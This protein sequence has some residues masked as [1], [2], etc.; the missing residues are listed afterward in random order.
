MTAPILIGITGKAGSGKDSLGAVFRELADFSTYALASPIKAALAAMLRVPVT[1]IEDREF[2]NAVYPPLG[3]TPRQMLQ[4]LGTEW[5]RQLVCEDIWLN[6]MRKRWAEVQHEIPPYLCVTDIR[7]D[8]EANAI[9]KE[10]GTLIRIIR[11]DQIEGDSHK[12]E[13]GVDLS[14]VDWTV[15]NDGS[16]SDL[17]THAGRILQCISV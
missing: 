15:Y 14:F 17:K 12:S 13:A 2:K 4:T 1:K 5:G 8:N 10:G 3:K 9:K 6:L 7:F 16:L 11:G